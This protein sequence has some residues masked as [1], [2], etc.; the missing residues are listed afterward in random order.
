MQCPVN[1]RIPERSHA[2]PEWLGHTI[3][4]CTATS[5]FR[6]TTGSPITAGNWSHNARTAWD[7][8]AQ[9]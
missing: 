2:T 8:P 1:Q 9:A 6:N 7:E 3:L 5:D 4:P